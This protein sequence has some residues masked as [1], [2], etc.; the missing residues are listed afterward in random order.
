MSKGRADGLIPNGH[1]A[2]A[3]FDL[4]GKGGASVTFGFCGRLR[5]RTK[6]LDIMLAAFA[7]Y[8]RTYAGRL[9]VIGDGGDRAALEAQAN[10][11]GISAD[12]EFVGAKFGAEKDALLETVD[13][14]LHP[15]RNEGMPGAVLEAAGMGIP[16][17]VSKETNL[18]E[19]VDAA[20]AGIALSANRAGELSAAMAQAL[21]AQK[22]GEWRRWA[23][24]ARK[25]VETT[26]SWNRI[27]N[28]HFNMYNS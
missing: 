21:Q 7:E 5:A 8:K 14:F 6:G 10:E 23:L 17:I 12:V 13:V 1:V 9:L 4:N 2:P 18:A 27:A 11:L 19:A 20:Q 16:V 22:S 26:F 3:S 24:N 15:S 28:L 25:M